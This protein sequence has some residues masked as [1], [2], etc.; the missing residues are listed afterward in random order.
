MTVVHL[1][2]HGEVFNPDR[3]LYGR[4]PGFQLSLR[5]R[6]QAEIA[7]RYLAARPIGHVVSSPLERARE[8][9]EPLV[10]AL[11]LQ[12]AIDDRLIEAENALEGT[13]VTGALGLLTNVRNWRYFLNPMRPSW[14]EPY[15]QIATRMGAAV[16]HAADVAAALPPVNGQPAQAV[17]VSHQ[18]PIYTLRRAVEGQRLYH[19][20]RRRECALASVTTLTLVD[21]V[22]VRVDYAEPAEATPA[23][24]VAGA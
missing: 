23:D 13:R 11:G 3:V 16:L 14:G 10:A 19:D 17:C 9:A 6:Q 22:V 20:P 1:L 8:T 24:A 2:R 15:Q 21:H 7:A 5:G 12:L 18:L 4:L